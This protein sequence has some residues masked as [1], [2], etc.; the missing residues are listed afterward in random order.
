MGEEAVLDLEWMD[1]LAATNDEVFDATRYRDV[2]LLVDSRLVSG[3]RS[4]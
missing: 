3:L 2:A 1:V 4:D